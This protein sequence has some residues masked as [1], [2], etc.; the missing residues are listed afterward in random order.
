MNFGFSNFSYILIGETGQE[1]ACIDPS[2]LIPSSLKRPKY[3]DQ[4]G[5]V[6]DLEKVPL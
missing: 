1:N 3:S 2:N 6:I 5:F 4:S